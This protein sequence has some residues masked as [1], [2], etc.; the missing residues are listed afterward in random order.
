MA[1]Q[2]QTSIVDEIG[3]KRLRR[4]TSQF[5]GVS[6]VAKDTSSGGNTESKF[7]ER[8]AANE[9]TAILGSLPISY[10]IGPG[11]QEVQQVTDIDLVCSGG[12]NRAYY[13][14]GFLDYLLRT[15]KFRI[16]RFAGA[17][18]GAWVAALHC[19]GLDTSTWMQTYKRTQDLIAKGCSPMEAYDKL[20]AFLPDDAH[21]R[22]SGRVFIS[23]TVV[24]ATRGV[25]NKIINTFKS[26]DD[27]WDACMS[28]SHIPF[29]ISKDVKRKFRDMVVL[30]G[31][32]LN[33]VPCFADAARDQLVLH[34]SKVTY[35]NYCSFVPV[36]PCIE[37]LTIRGALEARRFFDGRANETSAEWLPVGSPIPDCNSLQWRISSV[38]YWGS[39]FLLAAPFLLGFKIL[40]LTS[41]TF[42]AIFASGHGTISMSWSFKIFIA[43]L[44]FIMFNVLSLSAFL[45]LLSVFALIMLAQFETNASTYK[46][47]PQVIL[48]DGGEEP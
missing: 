27:L 40:S 14:V 48:G 29:V 23:L 45:I 1:Q 24:S 25:E 3:E 8:R 47:S 41:S 30:D 18:A 43:A 28:S 2:R 16:N 19:S 13:V 9:L 7:H 21:I 33:N 42:K 38:A 17:S 15:G 37:A 20:R 31:A 22:C 4:T 6:L 36:D 35:D 5:A 34:L 12:G 10:P 44:T 32:L 46:P 11:G 39:L 26:K